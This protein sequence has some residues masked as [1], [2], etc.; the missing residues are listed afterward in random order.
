MLNSHYFSDL[1][2]I[3]NNY[4][5]NISIIIVN[6]KVKYFLEQCL[7]SIEKSIGNLCVEVFVVD[8]NSRDGSVEFVE[9]NFP[10]IK[11][12]ANKTNYGFSYANNQAIKQAKGK[13]ILILNPDTIIE[14]DTLIKCFEFMNDD[15]K[16]GALGVK[17]ID[18]SGNFLSESKRALPT[19]SVA[20]FKIFGLS[21]LFP[22]SKKF[23]KYHLTYLDKDET[24][25]VDVLSGAFMFV[26]KTVLDKI[27]L[28]DEQFFMYGEDI[29]LSYR[30][31]SSGNKIMYFPKTKIIHFKGESTKKGSFNYVRTFYEAMIIFARK[32]FANNNKF[33][34]YIFFINFA[35]YLKASISIL[36]AFFSKISLPFIDFIIIYFGYFFFIPI[37]EN[38]KY[39]AG[40]YPKH[41]VKIAI[42]VI[43]AII[44]IS[45]I[46][47]KIYVK[48]NNLFKL[49]Q[50]LFMAFVAVMIIYSLLDEDYRF[51]RA[52]VIFGAFWSLI[53]SVFIR[54]ILKTM[55]LIKFNFKRKE[56]NNILIIAQEEEKTRI[57]NYLREN[58]SNK[59]VEVNFEINNINDQEI[60]KINAIVELNKID[61][62][63]FSAKDYLMNEIINCMIKLSTYNLA[64]KLAYSETS[65]IIGSKSKNKKGNI[66][67]LDMKNEKK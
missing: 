42:P 60:E 25:E 55:K 52:I 6:F 12:I 1:D 53:T 4:K 17:M 21:K 48:K 27:G 59:I 11:L 47:N 2:N 30:I 51:S 65:S 66:Y 39:E 37:W 58:K 8:N 41:L 49:L 44:I 67:L 50:S 14:E 13:Y 16:I 10:S 22:K 24:N 19:P 38:F 34:F 61:E 15:K 26:R 23:G 29:D 57:Y 35:I 9:E 56:K 28:F 45:F 32:H 36:T 3:I 7:K 40:Y 18:G 31:Q 20:F 54:Y 64:F 5:L 33:N 43:T 62:L 46:A 63:I